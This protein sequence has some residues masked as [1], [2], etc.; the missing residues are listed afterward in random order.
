VGKEAI[1]GSWM[2]RHSI[3]RWTGIGASLRL[4][5]MMKTTRIT[6]TTRRKDWILSWIS[7]GQT[8]NR[9]NNKVFN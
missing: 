5:M 8:R 7:I 1:V 2:S 9:M 3:D 4:M 6:R